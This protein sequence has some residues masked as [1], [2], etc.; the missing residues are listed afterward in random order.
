MNLGERSP[1]ITQ[2]PRETAYFRFFVPE[3]AHCKPFQILI[4]PYYG[5]PVFFL[6]NLIAFPNAETATWRKGKVPPSIAWA[7]NSFVVCPNAHPDY[8]LGTYSLAVFSWYSSSYYVEI[9]VS[10]Q[11]YP[12]LPPP[13]RILCDDVPESELTG[14]QAGTN[15]QT[16]CL[17]DTES[18]ELD[19]D[20][21]FAGGFTQY[22]LPV[23]A[24]FFFYFFIYFF[25]F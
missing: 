15:Q 16:Y 7:Q 5:A 14:A 13:G 8:R 1:I 17:Q 2:E 25:W 23:P 3:E 12:L 6:S 19:F 22:V 21:R 11:D 20:D 24:G 18:L 10:P 9:V 4:R